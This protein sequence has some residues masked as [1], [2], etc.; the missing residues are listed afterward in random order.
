MRFRAWTNDEETEGQRADIVLVFQ[1]AIHRHE[2]VN[3]AGS[4]PPQLAIL[5]ARPN[6]ALNGADV[7]SGELADQVVSK[8]LVKQDAHCSEA[9]RAPG[10]AP[11][12][13]AR[14]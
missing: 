13:L 1:L 11:R 14:V 8:V 10:P 9:C 5:Y 7:V 12:P 3:L 6:Q 2:N 4:T